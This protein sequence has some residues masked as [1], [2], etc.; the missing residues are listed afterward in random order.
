MTSKYRLL[1]TIGISMI[2]YTFQDLQ[3]YYDIIFL[4]LLIL[5]RNG[6]IIFS[7]LLLWYCQPLPLALSLFGNRL[8]ILRLLINYKLTNINKSRN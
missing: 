1:A 4:I 8:P 5:L 3:V 2:G 6:D 7:R